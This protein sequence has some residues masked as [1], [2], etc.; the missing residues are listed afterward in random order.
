M[1]ESDT[2]RTM[3]VFVVVI[4]HYSDVIMSTTAS[5]ITV[6]SIVYSTVHS[7][8]DQRKH[9][10]SATLAFVRGIHRW[11]VNSPH[12]GP[13]THEMF[14][15][16]DVIIV[17]S[18]EVIQ[19]PGYLIMSH[20]SPWNPDTTHMHNEATRCTNRVHCVTWSERHDP[21]Q[22]GRI[23]S[24][25]NPGSYLLLPA[26]NSGYT[27][28]HRPISTRNLRSWGQYGSSEVWKAHRGNITGRCARENTIIM[29]LRR[30][31]AGIYE[32]SMV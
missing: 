16:D 17:K 11:P 9:Q 5:Q 22:G 10:S 13:V 25:W 15:F 2:E 23:A 21:L 30:N 29:A 12:K 1:V 14:P 3:G 24:Y 19:G 32:T 8:A 18:L 28:C 6:V 27:G 26:T 7:Y 20:L 4:W 31:N